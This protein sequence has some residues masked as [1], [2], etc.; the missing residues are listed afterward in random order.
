MKATIKRAEFEQLARGMRAGYFSDGPA[1]CDMNGEWR[2]VEVV[3]E[4][5]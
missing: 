4:S 2:Q 1:I 5:V 3:D